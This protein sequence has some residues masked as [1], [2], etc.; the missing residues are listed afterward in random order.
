M[1][2]CCCISNVVPHDV[3][4]R[5]TRTV[6]LVPGVGRMSTAASSQNHK[7]ERGREREREREGARERERERARERARERERDTMWIACVCVSTRCSHRRKAYPEV[8]AACVDM[9]HSYNQHLT[10]NITWSADLID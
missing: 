7:R 1:H 2:G 5:A 9:S 10:V 3:P 6:L 8:A 4:A